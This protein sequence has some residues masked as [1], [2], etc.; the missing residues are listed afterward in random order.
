MLVVFIHPRCSCSRATLG[1]LD[2]LI[3]SASRNVD[4]YILFERPIGMP[5]GW[6]RAYLWNT[7]QH[8]SGAHVLTDINGIE[9]R[10]FGAQT[11]GQT[12]L[13]SQTGRLEFSGGITP[14]RGHYG[15]SAGRYAI[16]SAL[17]GHTSSYR[18]TKVYGCALFN[19]AVVPAR[20]ASIRQRRPRIKIRG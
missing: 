11:S 15:D 10:R 4:T 6:E 7:A 5:P 2:R 18:S 14:M 9:A 16:L 17:A 8:I 1:E 13:Y 12:Y 3:A 19:A 20:K